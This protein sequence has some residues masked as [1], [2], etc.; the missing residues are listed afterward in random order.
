MRYSRSGTAEFFSGLGATIIFGTLFLFT[1]VS[2]LLL[3]GV[4]AGALPMIRG[5]SKMVQKR[6]D[7]G[8]QKRLEQRSSE[9]KERIILRLARAEHGR[10]TPAVVA[11]NSTLS[12]DEAESQLQALADKGYASLEVTEDGRLL[13]V[14]PEFLDRDDD[15]DYLPPS[16]T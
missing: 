16:A 14:F 4:F 8:E 13:Y 5:L 1:N 12:L 9:S 10:L 3:V 15:Q 2:I 7:R 11:V 6:V